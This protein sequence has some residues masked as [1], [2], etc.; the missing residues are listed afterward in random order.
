MN[1]LVPGATLTAA[2]A[3]LAATALAAQ[4][5][6][7]GTYGGTFKGGVGYVSIHAEKNQDIEVE[8]VRVQYS[9]KGKGAAVATP[10]GFKAVPISSDGRFVAEFTG[11]ITNEQGDKTGARG[12]VRVAGRFRTPKLVR[13]VAGVK[14][15]KCG[16]KKR[17]F[18]ARG[19]QVEG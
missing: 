10:A 18:A 13:G 9:C 19:P 12:R 16:M 6:G 1:R 15:G 2:A 17:S 11:A 4:P 7:P 3:A 8:A 5:S 14:S